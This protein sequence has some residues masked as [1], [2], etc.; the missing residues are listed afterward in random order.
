MQCQ[1]VVS[2]LGQS[3]RCPC[4]VLAPRRPN[5]A[6]RLG[7]NAQLYDKRHT[8]EHRI[9]PLR[10]SKDGKQSQNKQPQARA[11]ATVDDRPAMTY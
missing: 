4:L 1:R 10:A 3:V 9:C 11:P 2:G 7:N 5:L 6:K 8:A